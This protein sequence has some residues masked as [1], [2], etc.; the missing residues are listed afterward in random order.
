MTRKDAMRRQRSAGGFTLIEVMVAVLLLLVA[1]AGFV[2][3]FL[4]GLGQASS[5]RYRSTATNIARQRMEEIRQL[6]YREIP[7]GDPARN[8]YSDALATKF[9]VT[10]SVRGADFTTSYAVEDV[11]YGSGNLKKVTVTVT[12]AAPPAPSPA[13]V[14]SL[15]HQQYLGPRGRLLTVAPVAADDLG[16]P[17]PQ[18]QRT[19]DQVTVKYHIAEADW[20]LVYPD[21]QDPASVAFNVYMRLTLVDDHGA[22]ITVGDP[23]TDYKILNT[24]LQKTWD[25]NGTLTDVYFEFP[26]DRLLIPD[27]Y[28]EMQ[29]V[30]YNEYDEPGNVWRMRLRFEEG[31]PNPPTDF[32]AI[33]GADNQ[34]VMLSWVPGIERDRDHYVLQ[35]Q[36]LNLN[37]DLTLSYGPWED[38]NTNLS[39]DSVVFTDVGSVAGAKDPWGS[40]TGSIKITNYYQYQIWAVDFASTPNSGPPATVGAQLPGPTTTT[41][42][43][44]G[45]TTTL[46]PT[47]TLGPTT[48][49]LSTVQIVNKTS[50]DYS[51]TV[52]D[53]KNHTVFTGTAAGLSTLSIPSLPADS[54][55]VDARSGSAHLS[56]S[57]QVPRDNGLT[58]LEIL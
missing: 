16:T 25:T 27:G 56:T 38:V 2:P 5:T 26:F 10:D 39:P 29:A 31:A 22:A 55:S 19:L 32:I 40:D 13:I 49:I 36:R 3:F 34:S 44:T 1:M 4:Q 18:V 11:A 48:T 50:L 20:G 42:I 41:T 53:S 54:Y 43:A 21:P 37:P 7:V 6:D 8:W 45:A 14:T 46:A 24:A 51:I 17:F 30:A 35:R 58:V 52:R 57:F 33:P 12:W 15:I 9:G 28:W 23:A 47:T